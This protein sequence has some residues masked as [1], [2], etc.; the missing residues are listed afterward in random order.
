MKEILDNLRANPS[1]PIAAIGILFMMFGYILLVTRP[2]EGTSHRQMI[3]LGLILLGGIF[4]VNAT[5]M[6]GNKNITDAIAS[7]A[8]SQKAAA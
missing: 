3:G 5:M 4:M 6:K 1:K 2:T 7:A 8:A